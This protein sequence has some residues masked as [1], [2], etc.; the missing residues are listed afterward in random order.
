MKFSFCSPGVAI[1]ELKVKILIHELN[2]IL[3]N[4]LIVIIY[5]TYSFKN[6][7]WFVDLW[8]KNDMRP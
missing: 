8:S 3:A 2:V 5:N 6:R 4:S 7:K 1:Y